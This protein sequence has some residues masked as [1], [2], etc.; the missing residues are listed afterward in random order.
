MKIGDKL[1]YFGKDAEVVDFDNTHVLIRFKSGAK[2]C[3][4]KLT[5]K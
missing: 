1:N 2:I 4:D 3:T 5:F